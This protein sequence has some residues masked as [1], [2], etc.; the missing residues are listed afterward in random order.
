MTRSQEAAKRLVEDVP[1]LSSWQ[2]AL[3]KGTG[4]G[5]HGAER[6]RGSMPI[7]PAKQK[8]K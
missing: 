4:A 5:L 6:V 3:T 7:F 8:L 1:F 2:E